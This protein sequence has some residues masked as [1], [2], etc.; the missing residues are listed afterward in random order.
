MNIMLLEV[1]RHSDLLNLTINKSINMAV[2]TTCEMRATLAPLNVK[3]QKSSKNATFV[4][5][6]FLTVKYERCRPRKIYN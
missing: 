4:R 5:I 1:N 2:V 3:S 6:Y